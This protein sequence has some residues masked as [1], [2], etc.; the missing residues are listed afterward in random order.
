MTTTGKNN[1]QSKS[2]YRGTVAWIPND[3]IRIHSSF[4]TGIKF[5]TISEIYGYSDTWNPNLALIPETSKGWDLGLET[6]LGSTD[7]TLDVTYYNNEITNLISGDFVN[8]IST[9]LPGVST[10]KGWE[11]SLHG[12][13]KEYEVSAHLAFTRGFRRARQ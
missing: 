1:F 10:T 13:L 2:T 6:G 4:G 12:T 5:P 8:S 7:L 11:F 3:H 9:N